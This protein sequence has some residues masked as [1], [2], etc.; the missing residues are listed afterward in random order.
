MVLSVTAYG[1]PLVDSKRS[2]PVVTMHLYATLCWY[3]SAITWVYIR[4]RSGLLARQHGYC[5]WKVMVGGAFGQHM[6]TLRI[7]SCRWCPKRHFS[8]SLQTTVSRSTIR[9]LWYGRMVRAT[10]LFAI[11]M[12]V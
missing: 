11:F 12:A 8:P 4:R 10:V 2:V 3:H 9:G 6:V 7:D 5:M 1:V